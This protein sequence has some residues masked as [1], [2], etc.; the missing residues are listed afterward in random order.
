MPPLRVLHVLCDCAGGGAERVVLALATR[1]SHRTVH[2]V[3]TIYEGGA[4]E[5]ELR[6]T[7]R[8]VWIGAERRRPSRA[9]WRR[10]AGLVREAD[11]VHTHLWAGDVW[12]RITG[13]WVGH[14]AIVS[15]IHNTEGDG[16]VRDRIARL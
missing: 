11:V 12:G 1:S 4:L 5:P 13:R 6:A 15:T 10:L 8:L 9:P 2:T 3:A 14:R 7:G 16:A